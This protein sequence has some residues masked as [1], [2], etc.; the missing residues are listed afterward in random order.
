[1]QGWNW[2]SIFKR[3]GPEKS[4][5]EQL[6]PSASNASMQVTAADTISPSSTKQ[7]LVTADN[8]QN[9]AAKCVEAPSGLPQDLDEG[10]QPLQPLQRQR[11]QQQMEPAAADRHTADQQQTDTGLPA[12]QQ[13]VD[14]ELQPLQQR[15]QQRHLEL[16]S[17]KRQQQLQ[18][19]ATPSKARKLLSTPS[20][21]RQQRQSLQQSAT[22]ARSIADLHR[23]AFDASKQQR[24]PAGAA[25]LVLLQG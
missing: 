6:P 25:S 19:R 10:L 20:P 21:A 2:N 7:P 14:E 9:Q 13:H 17:T 1:V 5:D 3:K 23:F 18:Q 4:A 12:Q 11:V 22:G 15:V 16:Q 24:T 8:K